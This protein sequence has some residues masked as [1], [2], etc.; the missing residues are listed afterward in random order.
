MKR[1]QFHNCLIAIIASSLFALPCR[2]QQVFFYKASLDTVAQPGFYQVALQPAIAAGMQPSLNDVRILDATGR[3]VPYLLKAEVPV[4]KENKFSSLPILSNKRET[5]KQVHVVIENTTGKPLSQLMLVIK[6]TTVNRMVTLSGSDDNINWYVIRENI[7]L[8]NFFPDTST[9]FI[10]SLSFP[11]S[12]YHY[13]KITL[14]GKDIL[15]VNIV[16]AGIYEE[17]MVNGKYQAL[18]SASLLQKDSIDKYSYIFI[19]LDNN[20]FVDRL[21]LGVEGSRFYKREMEVLGGNLTNPVLLGNFELNPAKPAVFSISAKTD[22]LLLKIK[23][24]DNPPL[25]VFAVT[26]FQLNRYLLAYLEKG[27]NYQLVWGDSTANA[28]SYDIEAFKDSIG[29]KAA[30]LNIGK[31]QLNTV[32]KPLVPEASLFNKWWLWCIILAA[33]VILLMLTFSLTKEINK[34]NS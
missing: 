10:Q 25:Q 7:Y 6:N 29:N 30:N 31:I 8:D 12:N 32:L 15:P 14:N 22:H 34:R 2:A 33:I 18:P 24:D 4:F 11:I 19:R 21:Q 1:N 9:T 20:Y 13:L 3:Q 26:A 5:D 28:P 16:R 17:T 27:N 23:N